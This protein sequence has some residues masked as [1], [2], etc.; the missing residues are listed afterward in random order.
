MRKIVL[1][2]AVAL[3][4]AGCNTLEGVGEDISSGARAID[5][6]I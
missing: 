2:A 6:A 1:F 4:L 3:A 5:R